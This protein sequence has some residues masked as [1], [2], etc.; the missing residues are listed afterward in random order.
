MKKHLI[1]GLTLLLIMTS[2]I[3]THHFNDIVRERYGNNNISVPEIPQKSYISFDINQ[4]QNQSLVTSKKLKNLFIPAIIYW[5]WDNTIEWKLNPLKYGSYFCRQMTL[6]A[7]SLNLDKILQNRKI[8][9]TIENFPNS[10][11]YTHKG[12]TL[13]LVV[14]Y[15]YSDV[16]TIIPDEK[17][18]KL[19]Y[20]ITKNDSTEFS[21]TVYFKLPY[22]PINNVWKSTKKYTWNFIDQYEENLNTLSKIVVQEIVED[23]VR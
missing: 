23:I 11:Y 19:T 4:L 6:Y 5:Q 1:H 13:I 9:I 20:Q 18:L 14:S 8:K 17:E 2:C 12:F 21:N 10:F 7:D 15:L 22:K 16:E 3:S